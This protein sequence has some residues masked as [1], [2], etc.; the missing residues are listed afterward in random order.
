MRRELAAL[1]TATVLTAGPLWAT[2][3]SGSPLAW[4]ALL[5]GALPAAQLLTAATS[6]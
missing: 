2:C 6:A 5:L 3:A 4:A 1:L